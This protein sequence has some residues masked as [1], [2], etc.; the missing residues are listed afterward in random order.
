MLSRFKNNHRYLPKTY[1]GKWGSSHI[2]N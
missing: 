1:K 2:Q